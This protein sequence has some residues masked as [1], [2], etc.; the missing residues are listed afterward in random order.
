[1]PVEH[2]LRFSNEMQVRNGEVPHPSLSKAR[3]LMAG[4]RTLARLERRN[5]GTS[6]RNEFRA[7]LLQRVG[8][9]GILRIR[10]VL[11]PCANVAQLVEQRTRNA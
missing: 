11:K 9:F 6:G 4:M 7:A 5:A 3:D 1:M 2:R 8:R 10:F